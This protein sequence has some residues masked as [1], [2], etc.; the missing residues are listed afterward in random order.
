MS[1]IQVVPRC[2]TAS[3]IGSYKV[4]TSGIKTA[5]CRNLGGHY[6]HIAS[7]VSLMVRYNENTRNM[8][9]SRITR[10][11]ALAFN[12]PEASTGSSSIFSAH[13]VL[14]IFMRLT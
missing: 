1:R 7:I 2:I 9:V 5:K 14:F 13:N 8:A 10:L 3:S 11:G 6:K 12:C 4:Q